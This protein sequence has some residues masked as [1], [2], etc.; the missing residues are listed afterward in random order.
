ML[1]LKIEDSSLSRVCTD[2]SANEALVPI[3]GLLALPHKEKYSCSLSLSPSFGGCTY[4]ISLLRF[5]R[6]HGFLCVAVVVC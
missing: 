5:A 1:N 4:V 3:L 2:F 6:G